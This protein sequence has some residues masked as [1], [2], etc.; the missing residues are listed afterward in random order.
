MR[1]RTVGHR[2]ITRNSRALAGRGSLLGQLFKDRPSSEPR[3]LLHHQIKPGAGIAA[4]V[5]LIP[6]PITNS[7]LA[8]VGCEASNSGAARMRCDDLVQPHPQ[9][10]DHLIAIDLI[11]DLVPALRINCNDRIDASSAIAVYQRA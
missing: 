10:T 7:L 9:L 4:D 11:Q 2:R 6:P 8:L 1:K 5:A 3:Q